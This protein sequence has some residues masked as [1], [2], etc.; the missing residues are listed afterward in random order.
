VT[1]QGQVAE[2]FRS[3]QGE[4]LLLGRRQVFVR[5]AG[6]VIDC[7]YCDTVWAFKAP[8]SVAMPGRSDLRV[9]NP[10]TAEQVRQL[11]EAADPPGSPGG[12][13]SLS[14]TGGEPLEQVDFC[15][16]L[17]AAMP[18]RDVMLETAA[19]DASALARL[20]PSL[21]WVAADLK[22]P[23]ATGRVDSLAEHEAVLS[24]GVLDQVETFF[25]LIVD[26]DVTPEELGQ[27]A[28]LLA[29]HAPGRQVFLQPVTPLG[30]SPALKP[31]Q[32]DALVDVLLSRALPVRVV[33]QVHKQLKVR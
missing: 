11:V 31:G 33:P 7:R 12:P 25:K 1:A 28:D 29:R 27:A 26:G 2:V 3:I 21:R 18:E 20:V 6:C 30:G 5:L 17:L 4:G 15:L 8:Q 9:E 13:A 24:C 16:A 14:L 22:L 23:S 19:L 32:L 10:M